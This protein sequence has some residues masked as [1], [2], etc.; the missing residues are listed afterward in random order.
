MAAGVALQDMYYENRPT[1]PP[2]DLTGI[3]NMAPLVVGPRC[4]TTPPCRHCWYCKTWVERE[5]LL[6][7]T[8]TPHP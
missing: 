2:I 6:R 7:F 5:R 3:A 4:T 8:G 1:F